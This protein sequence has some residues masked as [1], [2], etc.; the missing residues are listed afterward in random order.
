MAKLALSVFGSQDRVFCKL[1]TT[2]ILPWIVLGSH[3]NTGA[4]CRRKIATL[5]GGGVAS[6]SLSE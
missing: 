4:R 3:L 2:L 1:Q 6:H 5:L